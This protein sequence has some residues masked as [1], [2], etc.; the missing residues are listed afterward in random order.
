MNAEI[1]E[2]WFEGQVLESL[3]DRSIAQ[4]HTI[5]MFEKKFKI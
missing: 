5:L 4:L 2:N 3:E 1:F